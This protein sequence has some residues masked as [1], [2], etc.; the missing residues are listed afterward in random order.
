MCEGMESEYKNS[1]E[2]SERRSQFKIMKDN[3]MFKLNFKITNT[4]MCLFL[5]RLQDEGIAS[6]SS[7]GRR[8]PTEKTGRQFPPTSLMG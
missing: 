7:G 6:S 1:E 4:K 2:F 5:F 8:R 3:F